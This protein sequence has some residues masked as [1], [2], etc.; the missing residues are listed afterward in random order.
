MQL[1]NIGYILLMIITLGLFLTGCNQEANQ[2]DITISNDLEHKE[3]Q[4]EHNN[5]DLISE[6]I[7]I[8]KC[9][10]EWQCTNW[11]ECTNYGI[12]SRKCSDI[13]S[14]SSLENKPLEKQSCTPSS[15]INFKE[16]VTNFQCNKEVN[17][18]CELNINQEKS[19]IRLEKDSTLN[20]MDTNIQWF[21]SL[22]EGKINSFTFLI[23]NNGCQKIFI[24]DVNDKNYFETETKIF[25][26]EKLI[27][28]SKQKVFRYVGLVEQ[29]TIK[30]Y[31]DGRVDIE[32]YIYPG[33]EAYLYAEIG[34]GLFQ[35]LKVSKVGNYYFV[36]D[37][38]YD[39][40]HVGSIKD[41]LIMK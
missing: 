12:Q 3:K 35:P 26:E 11:S 38:Y 25:F 41:I 9:V 34:D 32:R 8:E 2:N 1:K 18:D 4:L 29:D 10:P 13:N 17:L 27:A 22:K 19:C 28:L 31:S 14:C 37:I 6:S 30:E 36:V 33:N 21:P 15:L 7:E 39:N 40:E 20:F 24:E 5:S 16:G 23:K